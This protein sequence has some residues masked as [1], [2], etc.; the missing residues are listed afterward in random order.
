MN[1]F[2]D[3]LFLIAK[4][5]ITYCSWLLCKAIQSEIDSISISLKTDGD[6]QRLVRE[7]V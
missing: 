2:N 3:N 4:G 1:D 5:N 6:I 7:D